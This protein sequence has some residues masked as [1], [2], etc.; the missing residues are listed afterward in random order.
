VVARTYIPVLLGALAML[1][2]ATFL[3][4]P[5]E[6]QTAAKCY[7]CKGTG[8]LPCPNKDCKT[9]KIC[10]TKLSH[11]CDAIWGQECCRGIG[12]ILC[13]KCKDP[14]VETELKTELESRKAWVDKQRKIDKGA[15]T[16]FAHVETDHWILHSS[17]PAWKV[18]IN[19]NEVT[20]NRVRAAHLWAE[21]LEE[22]ATFVQKILGSYTA[23]KQSA[24]LVTNEDEMMR[25]TLTVQGQGQKR[26]YKTFGNPLGIFTTAP[27]DE[28]ISD[29]L[30]HPHVVHSAA[31]IL[32]H[33]THATTPVEFMSTWVHEAFAHWVE[34]ERFGKQ[35]T[36]CNE[37]VAQA[38]NPWRLANWK[39]NVYGEVAGRKDEPLAAIMGRDTDRLSD[40]DRAH[41][42]AFLEFLTETRKP[43]EF[44]KFIE[45]LK[46]TSGDTK[47]AMQTAYGWSTATFQEKWREYVLKTWAP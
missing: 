46:S 38:N 24:C 1:V 8:L 29:E 23:Q 34:I 13:P 17:F 10:G 30:F 22:T 20:Y 7:Q 44:R 41:G 19:E 47:K 18:K 9:E 31:H 36:F 21:R 5:L 43:E 16:R 6:A 42:W 37:E 33:A 26:S 35:A 40:R 14:I 2:S 3:A 11:K 45:T 27:Y 4:T 28:F 32:L 39:R 12:K 15:Q 25:T